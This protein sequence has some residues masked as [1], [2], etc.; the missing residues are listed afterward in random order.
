MRKKL[1]SKKDKSE[2]MVKASE[3]YMERSYW[4]SAAAMAGREAWTDW[5]MDRR[6]DRLGRGDFD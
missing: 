6:M 3:N 1:A 4:R 2:I 5:S